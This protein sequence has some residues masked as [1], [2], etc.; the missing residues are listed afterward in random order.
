M[1]KENTPLE[2]QPCYGCGKLFPPKKLNQELWSRCKKCV[3][4]WLEWQE[5]MGSHPVLD[6]MGA[7][8]YIARQ[9]GYKKEIDK[10]VTA[11]DLIQPLDGEGRPNP[12][13]VERYGIANY[14]TEHKEIIRDT[15]GRDSSRE[16]DWR[17]E[18]R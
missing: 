16:R 2:K 5:E 6:S 3:E 11:A 15:M 14:T 9:R 13:F 10:G 18:K 1:K 17:A 12:D 8:A 7:A 4:R